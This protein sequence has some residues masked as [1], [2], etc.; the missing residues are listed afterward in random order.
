[1]TE[2]FDLGFRTTRVDE[3]DPEV[4]SGLVIR[5]EPPAGSLHRGDE[6]V[7]IFVSSG[8]EQVAVPSVQGLLV[9]SAR[10]T[11]IALGF[12]VVEDQQETDN[13][14]EV[15]TVLAQTPPANIEVD[16]GGTVTIVIGI[17]AEVDDTTTTVPDDG[18]GGDGGGE[19]PDDPP[20]DDPPDDPPAGDPPDDPPAGDGGDGDGGGDGADQ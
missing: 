12:E 9:D 16:E 17:E 1:M 15:N 7:T 5:T 8:L 18:N 20:A 3:S 10:Q 14:D 2:L 11:L 4:E 6:I 19:T 13:P